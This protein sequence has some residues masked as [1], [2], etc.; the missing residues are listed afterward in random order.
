[1]KK[2]PTMPVPLR[3]HGHHSLLVG[4]DGPRAVVERAREL[5]YAAIA[6]CD[7]DSVAGI[8]E[9]V[10]GGAGVNNICRACGSRQEA[11]AGAGG[12]K[13]S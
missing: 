5:G 1:M 4:V 7:V 11:T 2:P 10:R 13:I 9:W 12:K 8:V 3:V 6:L